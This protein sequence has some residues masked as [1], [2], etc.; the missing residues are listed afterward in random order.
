MNW[1]CSEAQTTVPVHHSVLGGGGGGLQVLFLN[2]V[3]ATDTEQMKC[4]H[5]GHKDSILSFSFVIEDVIKN[6]SQPWEPVRCSVVTVT[7]GV[8]DECISRLDFVLQP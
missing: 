2:P 1:V 8:P 6:R 5:S 3:K 7:T 4:P